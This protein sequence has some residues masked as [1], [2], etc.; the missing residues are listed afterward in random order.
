[1]IKET[2]SAKDAL[3]YEEIPLPERKSGFLKLNRNVAFLML[4]MVC[5]ASIHN[6]TLPSGKTVLTALQQTVDSDWDE[7]LGQITFVDQLLPQTLSVFFAQP[8]NTSLSLPCLGS[9]AHPWQADAPYVSFVPDTSAALAMADGEVMNVSHGADNALTLRIRHD[10]GLESVYYHLSAVFCREGDIVKKGDTI[11]TIS[12]GQNL[13]VDVRRDGLS[14]DP[15]AYF[16]S[17]T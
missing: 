11:A 1:M 10:S 8:M 15:A 3:P 14:V 2:G 17:A 5:L 4:L 6:S 12:Q 13:V 16:S 9:M 7:T